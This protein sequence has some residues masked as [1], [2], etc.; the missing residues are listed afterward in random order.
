[1]WK[2][3]SREVQ[4]QTLMSFSASQF[5]ETAPDNNN[6]PKP[7]LLSTDLKAPAISAFIVLIH[8]QS[9]MSMRWDRKIPPI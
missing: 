8:K 3:M 5:R 6:D 1:M 4:S 9:N 2:F 7:I